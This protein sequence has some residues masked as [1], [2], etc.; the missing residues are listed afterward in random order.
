MNHFYRV[1]HSLCLQLLAACS[2]MKHICSQ[3]HTPQAVTRANQV[4]KEVWNLVRNAMGRDQGIVNRKYLEVGGKIYYIYIYTHMSIY[5]RVYMYLHISMCTKATRLRPTKIRT[6]LLHSKYHA[7]ISYIL[8]IPENLYLL[9]VYDTCGYKCF[10][11]SKYLNIYLYLCICISTCILSIHLYICLYI[12]IY[13]CY[14]HI[15][16]NL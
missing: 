13:V 10:K 8:Y 3:M 1:L 7:H 9:F 4:N 12:Y 16:I 5:I 6:T 14:I 11:I 15:S 2:T